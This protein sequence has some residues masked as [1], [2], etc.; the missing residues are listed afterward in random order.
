MQGGISTV[1]QF[2]KINA[3]TNPVTCIALHKNKTA[4][5]MVAKLDRSSSLP[6]PPDSLG[7]VSYILA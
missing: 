6:S 2:R 7:V 4:N 5:V 3:T 1:G